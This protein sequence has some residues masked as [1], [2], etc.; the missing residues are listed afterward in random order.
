[1]TDVA[2]RAGLSVSDALG[3]LGMLQLTG[4]ARENGAGWARGRS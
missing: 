3:A 4:A 1:V 2:R